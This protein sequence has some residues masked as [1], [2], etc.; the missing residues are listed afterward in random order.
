M[1]YLKFLNPIWL[2]SNLTLTLKRG[3]AVGSHAF[4]FEK[5]FLSPNVKEANLPILHAKKE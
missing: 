1:K 2:G 3:W 4:L 5:D